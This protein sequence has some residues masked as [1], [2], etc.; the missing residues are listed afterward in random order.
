MAIQPVTMDNVSQVTP[1][2]AATETTTSS[3]T[4]KIQTQITSK[5]QHMKKVSS[6]DTITATEKEEKRRQLQKEI[7]ELNRKLELKKREQEEK[8]KEAAKKQE[9][10]AALKE[11]YLKKDIHNK[12]ISSSESI[13]D[14]EKTELEKQP[15]EASDTLEKEEPKHA[16][17]PVKEIQEMLSAEYLMQKEQLQKQIDTK[18]EN[19]IQVVKSEIKQDKSYGVDTTKKEAELEALQQKQNFWSDIQKQ[20]NEVEVQADNQIQAQHTSLNQNAKVII[21]QI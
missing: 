19:T 14:K 2:S 18:A 15:V 3:D 8:A 16:D 1:T 9:Q 20:T 4:K 7:D 17:M 13:S 6:D 10:A 5:Q 21:D 12:E 11:E